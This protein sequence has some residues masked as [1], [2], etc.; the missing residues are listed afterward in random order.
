MERTVQFYDISEWQEQSYLQTGGTR[1]KIVV[2]DINSGDLYY[3]K[4]SL[5]RANDS[6]RY[7][8]WS[9]IIAA[10][11][12]VELG[13][14][15][16]H[17]DIALH[18]NEVGCLSKSMINADKKVLSELVEYLCSYDNTYDPESKESYPQYTFHFI[19]EALNAHGL[20]DMI[21]H[22]IETIIFD[23]I[24]GNGDRHQENWGFIVPDIQA[25]VMG[26]A[27]EKSAYKIP[28]LLKYFKTSH[29]NISNDQDIVSAL[30]IEFAPIYD[31]GSSLGRELFDEKVE[32]MLKDK[33][34]F[35]AY[36]SHDRCEIRWNGSKMSHF[37]LLERIV[38]EHLDY[39]KIVI[40]RIKQIVSVL[41]IEHIEKIVYEIDE[42]LLP[43]LD[44][45]KLPDYR[46]RFI[47][48]LVLLRCDKLKELI[49]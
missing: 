49:K 5:K 6:Y 21:R 3:F 18:R 37:E 4:T 22:I 34:M 28:L 39:K 27:N 44:W 32:Q 25:L 15:T 8:F 26:E 43:E 46:K 29:Q 16:L 41:N 42:H 30:K 7:E 35:H 9:E 11:I 1:N 17:Y 48:Q 36:L 2:E 12:G 45:S 23:S 47:C 14:N 38:A 33:Q 24:I 13:F 19:K 20:G 31:S 10:A 40:D